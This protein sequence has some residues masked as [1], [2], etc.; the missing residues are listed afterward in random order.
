VQGKNNEYHI[1]DKVQNSFID[2]LLTMWYS[3]F[4]LCTPELTV[5]EQ[6]KFIDAAFSVVNFEDFVRAVERGGEPVIF[7]GAQV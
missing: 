7:T 1:V 5:Q 3:L 2:A 4:L 6:F